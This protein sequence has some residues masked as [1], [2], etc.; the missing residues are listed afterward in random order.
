MIAAELGMQSPRA[1]RET[2]NFHAWLRLMRDGAPMEPRLIRTHAPSSPGKKFDHVVAQARARHMI[3][4]ALVEAR[5]NASFPKAPAKRPRRR[6][7]R[8]NPD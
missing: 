2:N 3:P 7:K 6:P 5:I 8:R 4:R 1:L